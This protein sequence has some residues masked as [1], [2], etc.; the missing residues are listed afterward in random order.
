M[1]NT[2][3]ETTCNENFATVAKDFLLFDDG[4]YYKTSLQEH[5][6]VTDNTA[7][8][9]KSKSYAVHKVGFQHTSST[10]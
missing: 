10:I 7:Y 3:S 5:N 2:N 9:S 1:C 8:N 4:E 6:F